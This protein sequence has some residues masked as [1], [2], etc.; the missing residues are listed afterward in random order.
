VEQDELPE[1]ILYS[2]AEQI[3]AQQQPGD[4]R[5]EGDEARDAQPVQRLLPSGRDGSPAVAGNPLRLSFSPS[6]T[7]P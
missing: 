1:T 3:R 4:P 7:Y 2:A 6:S 5:G